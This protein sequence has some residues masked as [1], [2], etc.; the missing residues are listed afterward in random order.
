MRALEEVDIL[1]YQVYAV[2]SVESMELQIH[3]H[4]FPLFVKWRVQYP[5]SRYELT[6]N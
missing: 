2:N 3:D 1:S 4:I 6:F 5:I